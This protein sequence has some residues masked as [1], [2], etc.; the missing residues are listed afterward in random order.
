MG[1]TVTRP[2]QEPLAVLLFD[3]RQYIYHN[4]AKELIW[5]LTRLVAC[6][7]LKICCQKQPAATRP[8]KT[9]LSSLCLLNQILV[10]KFTDSTMASFYPVMQ[11]KKEI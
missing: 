6:S 10:Q 1:P 3:N 9:G 7:T 8:I 11:V 5:P 4:L 2:V